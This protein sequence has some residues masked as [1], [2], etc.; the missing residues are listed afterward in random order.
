MTGELYTGTGESSETAEWQM[1]KANVFIL[2]SEKKEIWQ[3]IGTLHFKF[4]IW[5]TV[6]PPPARGGP[7]HGPE[8]KREG[9]IRI[10][11]AH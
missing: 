3:K 4:C 8:P 5:R 6:P 2:T 1:G 7:R 11:R 10:G 9:P